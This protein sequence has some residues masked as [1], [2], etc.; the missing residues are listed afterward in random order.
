MD[1]KLPTKYLPN[2]FESNQILHEQS[3]KI[4]ASRR[5]AMSMWYWDP[6]SS[7]LVICTNCPGFWI[8]AGGKDIDAIKQRLNDA[9]EV[10]NA[11]LRRHNPEYDL[12]PTIDHIA[13]FECSN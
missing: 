9:I 4:R 2:H 7:T 13:F 8:G 10:H 12:I 6:S 5:G 1:R 3:L 11:A